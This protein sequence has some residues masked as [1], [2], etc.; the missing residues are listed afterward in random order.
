MK[1][2]FLMALVLVL[3]FSCVGCF[4]VEST[5]QAPV[6]VTIEEKDE[7]S[8]LE[9]ELNE[10][11]EDAFEDI[12]FSE[13]IQIES[14][15]EAAIAETVIYDANDVKVT[16]K[17]LDYA[18]LFGI[19]LTVL[20]ENNSDENITLQTR[21][22]SVNGFMV[23]PMFSCDV[24]AG[25]KAND[26]IVFMSSDLQAA[27]IT[28]IQS[29]E[30]VLYL[31][32]AETWDEID[33][34]E[35]I[36]ITTDA[37]DYVQ[38]VDDSGS[39]AYEADGIKIV[40]KAL[41]SEDS[42]WGSDLYL[43]IENNSGENITVQTRDCSVNGFMIDPVFS[44]EVV[45]GKKALDSIVFFESDLEENGITTFESIELSFHIFETESWDTITDTEVITMTF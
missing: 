12:D 31:I 19:G 41:D 7:T 6:D 44:S 23:D 15:T 14:V 11:I 33:T 37:A 45:N 3:A 2:L 42:L 10:V 36:T 38:S 35:V 27:D 16:V 34:S 17:S 28:T 1:K 8:V 4:G 30:L 43:Y 18:D 29:I 39:V 9:E 40:V 25:K 24:A 13:D 32:E 5:S 21:N 20:V 26:S 22:T